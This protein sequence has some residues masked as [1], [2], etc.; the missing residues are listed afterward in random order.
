VESGLSDLGTR[1]VTASLGLHD[2]ES[3]DDEDGKPR[4]DADADALGNRSAWDRFIHGPAI[5]A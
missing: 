5:Y 4:H 3:Q 1:R 2:K